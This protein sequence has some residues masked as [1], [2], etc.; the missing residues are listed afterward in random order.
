MTRPFHDQITHLVRARVD[1]SV[2][3]YRTL[4]QRDDVALQ[5]VLCKASTEDIVEF[6]CNVADEDEARAQFI[7]AATAIAQ[8]YQIL[9][10]EEGP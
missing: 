10:V 9:D 7:E 5:M 8:T 3:W 6:Y 1:D 4:D 2:V